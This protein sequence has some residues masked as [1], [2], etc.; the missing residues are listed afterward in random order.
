VLHLGLDLPHG[1]AS[2]D[3]DRLEHHVA[4]RV[5]ETVAGRPT[6]AGA[7]VARTAGAYALAVRQLT[8]GG[9]H[10]PSDAGSKNP[11]KCSLLVVAK[12]GKW[13]RLYPKVGGT[14]DDQDGFH[15]PEPGVAKVTADL[16]Q[17]AIDPTRP[18]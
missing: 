7:Y 1:Q 4:L 12:G 17:G 10:A 3:G 14:D 5:E 8:A 18:S 2:L 13:V 6:Y 15:C 16:G 11:T 9:L